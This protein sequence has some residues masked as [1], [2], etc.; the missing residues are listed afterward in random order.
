ML[1][2]IILF[3]FV[4]LSAVLSDV[5]ILKNSEGNIICSD[6]IEQEVLIFF[7]AEAGCYRFAICIDT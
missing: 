6:P 4:I 2:V 1:R 5:F 7:V 3:I